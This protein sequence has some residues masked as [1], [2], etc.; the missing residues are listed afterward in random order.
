MTCPRDSLYSHAT[1]R[2]WDGMTALERSKRCNP[3]SMR[4]FSFLARALAVHAPEKPWSIKTGCKTAIDNK[5]EGL[6]QSV[7]QL[8][9]LS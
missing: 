4:R 1:F 5:K 7:Q 9:R 6:A 2:P 3:S 8:D